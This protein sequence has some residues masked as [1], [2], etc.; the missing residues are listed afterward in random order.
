MA[1][2]ILA[3]NRNRVASYNLRVF[4]LIVVNIIVLYWILTQLHG[5]I[6]IIVKLHRLVTSLKLNIIDKTIT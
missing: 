4:Y 2:C 6:V 3:Q 5:G 1:N